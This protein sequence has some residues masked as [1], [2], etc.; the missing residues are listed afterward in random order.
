MTLISVGLPVYNAADRLS[1][2][3]HSVL[4]QDHEDVELVIS[5]NAST[6][7]TEDVCRELAAKDDRIVYHRQPENRGILNN[8][9]TAMRTARGEYFRWIGDDDRLEPSCLS[10]GLAAFQA[11]P[12]VILVTNQM[13]YEDADGSVSTAPYHGRGLGSDDPVERFSEMLRLLNE[14]HLEIDPLYGLMRRDR[15]LA[16]PRRNMLREDEVF[17]TKLALAGPWAHVN[18]VLAYRNR[19]NQRIGNIARRLGV[20]SWQSHFA[21]TLECQEMLRWLRAADLTGEQRVR[22]RAAVYR[23]YLRRQERTVRHRSRKL[24]RLMTSRGSSA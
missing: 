3:V 18:Q 23:M 2:V 16:I 13:G 7:G 8:F 1:D 10:V 12:R 22:A 17:A 14:S 20:P 15:V 6:D 21:N 4:G 19:S 9:V 5:D 11:D 24:V